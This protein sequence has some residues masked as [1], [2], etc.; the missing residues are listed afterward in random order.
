MF[1]INTNRNHCILGAY[2]YNQGLLT[3]SILGLNM[4]FNV[5]GTY[6]FL[7]R[8]FIHFKFI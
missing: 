2:G 4:Y 6:P 8:F 3:F 7:I 5:I 1:V